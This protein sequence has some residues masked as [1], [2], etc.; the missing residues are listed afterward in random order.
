MSFISKHK[1]QQLTLC[2]LL[3][4]AL[5]IPAQIAFAKEFLNQNTDYLKNNDKAL[6]DGSL[7]VPSLPGETTATSEP[8]NETVSETEGH[9][10]IRAADK[11]EIKGPTNIPLIDEATLSL[12]ADY[13]FI[14]QKESSKLLELTGN[15]PDPNLVGIVTQQKDLQGWIII[16]TYIKSG[17]ISDSDAK[18]WKADDL[19][20]SIIEGTK[21]SNEDRIAKGIPTLEV[22][23][24]AE[25]PTYD[26]KKNQLIYSILAKDSEANSQNSINYRTYA[27]GRDGYFDLTLVT[28]ES[29]IDTDKENAKKI[30]ASLEFNKSK[31]YADFNK[32]TDHMAEYGLAALVT[33]VVVKKLGL[34]ALAGFWFIKL[35]KVL[36]VLPLLIWAKL[37]KL[38]KK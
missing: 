10:A 37:K 1:A 11:A 6:N 13:I 12:P 23:G 32:S 3:A 24:W 5:Y 18:N 20:N 16:I 14:P 2:V 33:G 38:V 8:N 36:I 21:Q 19:L 34:L 15:R 26:D 22:L 17:Y 31:H 9:A 35:W 7:T 4:T 27:L 25:R 30:L 28:D 29:T